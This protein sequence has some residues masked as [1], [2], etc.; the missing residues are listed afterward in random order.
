MSLNHPLP[1]NQA[2]PGAP[3]GESESVFG[4]R[5]HWDDDAPAPDMR[6]ADVAQLQDL[7][8]M[9]MT[10]ATWL[11]RKGAEQMEQGGDKAAG[12]IRQLSHSFNRAARALRQIVVLKHE[13]AELRPLPGARPAV[14]ANQNVRRGGGSPRASNSRRPWGRPDLDDYT[15]DEEREAREIEANAWLEKLLAALQ[16]DIEAAGPEVVAEAARE[17]IAVKLSTIAASIPH[18]TLDACLADIEIR[19]LWNIFAPK[20]ARNRAQGP[21]P[22]GG[23]PADAEHPTP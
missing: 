19:K 6:E 13:V 17:S 23:W 14:P 1:H 22:I 16:V 9:A 4:P 3:T 5:D 15:D 18:P 20:Y 8:A 2:A 7:Q 21:P 11:H 10:F 12:E